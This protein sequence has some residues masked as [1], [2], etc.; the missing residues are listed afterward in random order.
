MSQT[1]SQT[2]DDIKAEVRHLLNEWNQGASSGFRRR[3][4]ARDGV[5]AVPRDEPLTGKAHDEPRLPPLKLLAFVCTDDGVLAA[6][7]VLA[8]ACVFM[9]Q[10]VL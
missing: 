5:A 8:A 2:E 3:H 4:R 9:S 1:M 10:W 6:T 7:W